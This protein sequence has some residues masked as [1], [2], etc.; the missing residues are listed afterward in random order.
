MT[1][2]ETSFGTLFVRGW[3]QYL[4]DA[5][6]GLWQPDE[7]FTDDDTAIVDSAELPDSPPRVIALSSYGVSDDVSLSNS[8]LALQVLCRWDGTDPA[9][10]RDLAEAVYN[11]LQGAQHVI[12]DT[13]VH[14]AQTWRNSGPASLG[15][16]ANERWQ[17]SSNFYCTC[18]RPS[19][20]RD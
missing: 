12:L 1:V 2:P 5:G 7:V 13:G 19:P 18:H 15:K 9:P 3:A 11:L 16:D 20:N 4:D 10:S 8:V 14:V 6:L 17:N